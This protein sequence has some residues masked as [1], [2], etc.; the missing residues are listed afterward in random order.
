MACT[1]FD[2][3]LFVVVSNHQSNPVTKSASTQ[4][5]KLTKECV[6][7]LFFDKS[8]NATKQFKPLTKLQ[9]QHIVNKCKNGVPVQ[10]FNKLLSSQ[11]NLTPEILNSITTITTEKLNHHGFIQLFA[12][13]SAPPIDESFQ[14]IEINQLQIDYKS[15]KR[16]SYQSY[17]P[18]STGLYFNFE[19]LLFNFYSNN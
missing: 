5:S 16:I 7:S 14:R 1:S 2:V 18:L 13:S 19:I 9:Y 4:I 8:G 6:Y 3:G 11:N 17:I 10:E 12:G 15:D